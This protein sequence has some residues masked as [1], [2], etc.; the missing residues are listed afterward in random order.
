M[1]AFQV[2][3][4]STGKSDKLALKLTRKNIFL[5]KKQPRRKRKTLMKLTEEKKEISL[6]LP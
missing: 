6:S 5:T 1:R 4:E 2:S 3:M